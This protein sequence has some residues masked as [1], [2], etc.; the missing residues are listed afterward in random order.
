MSSQEKYFK[1]KNG[2]QFDD[3]TYVTTA[4]GLRGPTGPQGNQGLTGPTGSNGPTGPT[5]STGAKGDTGNTGPTGSQGP[6]GASGTNGTNGSQ[7]PTGAQGPTG[8]V[9][10]T[11][12]QGSQGIAGPTGPQ[13]PTGNTGAT[14]AGGPT[15][16][17]GPTGSN[18]PTGPGATV[19]VGIVSSNPYGSGTSVT[20]TGTT[21]A[22]YFNFSL[23]TGPTGATGGTGDRGG[24]KYSYSSITSSPPTS[25]QIRFDNTT[26]SSVVSAYIHNSALSGTDISSYIGQWANSTS[27]IKGQLLLYPSSGS[28]SI[29]A[30]WNITA[31][32]NNSTYYTLTLS[33]GTGALPS[34]LT[35]VVLEF[36][37][38]G[39]KGDTG[40]TGA[41][42]AT[43]NTGATGNVG[44]TGPN[45]LGYDG[46]TSSTSKQPS[47]TVGT[48]YSWT[49]NQ[50]QGSNAYTVGEYVYITSAGFGDQLWGNITAYSGTTLTVNVITSTGGITARSDWLIS[51][52]G[53]RGPT[54]PAGNAG[55]NGT[56]GSA[57]T[58]ACLLYTSP[59]PRD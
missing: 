40:A 54:G 56:N 5:G 33:N 47:T 46:L 48:T 2:L 15:G 30:V 51:L 36:I 13:G 31:I 41:Q 12:S 21:S 57:A 20:N 59:S 22:A 43:G 19:A 53:T 50:A 16:P 37:R 25:G 9:G 14:G 26:P 6:T 4:N 58:V 52:S 23:E 7:G 1:I 35:N 38:T 55:T 11:G 44:P 34:N 49:V 24:I 27:A 45:G 3:G 39:D 18:G 17:G 29:P 10:P 32:T 8:S 42:G 28:S